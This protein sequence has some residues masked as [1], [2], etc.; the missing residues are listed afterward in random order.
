MKML[1]AARTLAATVTTTLA[2][3]ALAAGDATGTEAVGEMQVSG[4]HILMGVGA[5][6]AMGLVIWG[7]TKVMK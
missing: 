6:G 4:V 2:S 1:H 5:I 7:V 3:V